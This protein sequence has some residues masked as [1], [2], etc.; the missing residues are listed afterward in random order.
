MKEIRMDWGT[1]QHEI[2]EAK[3]NNWRDGY[4]C[5][6]QHI[7]KALREQEGV[8]NFF[9]NQEIYPNSEEFKRYKKLFV[10]AGRVEEVRKYERS[11]NKD[12]KGEE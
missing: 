6:V 11:F 9:S 1:Y 12:E 2:Y 4:E 7:E 5:A 10:S 8:L 3:G